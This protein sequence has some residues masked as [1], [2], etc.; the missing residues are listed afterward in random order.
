M[1]S[2]R[3]KKN[4]QQQDWWQGQTQTAY[5]NV[6]TKTPLE[7]QF[8]ANQKK[9]LDWDASD[10]KDV[11]DAQGLDSY[12]QIG[13]AAQERGNQ[14]RMGTGALAL[15][16]GGASGYAEKLKSLQNAQR[17]ENFGS[18]L[19]NA[20]AARRAEAT[21][22]VMPLAQLDLSRKNA[23]LG[24]ATGMTGMYLNRPKTRPF[25]QDL[26]MG[27]IQGAS[28]VGAAAAGGAV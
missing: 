11:R 27:I 18:G 4:N 22:S 26:T 9:F 1:S 3:E 8:E 6:A 14:Q 17:G 7:T 21:G 24:S 19:E 13:Q 20:L 23:Q 28:Q 5:N 16:D 2:G 12:I 15:S 10:G 25:W